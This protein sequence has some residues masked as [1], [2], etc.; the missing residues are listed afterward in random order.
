MTI[1]QDKKVRSIYDLE[2][3]YDVA[4]FKQKLHDLLPGE[5]EI[6]T[7]GTGGSIT[8]MGE[9]SS[10][11]NLSQ[12]LA[13]AG[14]YV[15][16]D[17]IVNQLQVGGIHQVML[18]VRVAEM[19]RTVTK[20]LGVNFSFVNGD[21]FGVSLL[22]GLSSFDNTG[23]GSDSELFLMRSPPSYVS[24]AGIPHGPFSSMP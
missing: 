13:L 4:G 20:R 19:S 11:A 6:R 5:T 3:A 10:T 18:E 23:G 17:K 9:V 14:A 2:V 22:G 15:P 1:W 24:A 21:D 16:K 7:I 8:L 12:V